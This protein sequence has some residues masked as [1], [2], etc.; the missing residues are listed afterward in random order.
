MRLVYSED[1]TVED[2]RTWLLENQGIPEEAELIYAGDEL[3]DER[4]LASYNIG[5]Y[6]GMSPLS[7]AP[8][9]C[10]STPTLLLSV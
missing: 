9:P 8:L 6:P 2:L 3:D 5:R 10:V 4:T 1:Y 7:C